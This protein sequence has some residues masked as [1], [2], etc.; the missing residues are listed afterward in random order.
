VYGVV[1]AA[2]VGT[3]D[4]GFVLTAAEVAADASAGARQTTPTSTQGCD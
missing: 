2:A 4:T 3:D 1:F